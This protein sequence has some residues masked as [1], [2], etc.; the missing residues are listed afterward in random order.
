MRR[1]RA[2][3]LLGAMLGPTVG[4][5]AAASS[6][7]AEECGCGAGAL[8]PMHHD[9]AKQKQSHNTDGNSSKDVTCIGAANQQANPSTPQIDLK[10][11]GVAV[12][13]NVFVPPVSDGVTFSR[14]EQAI[15]RTISPPYI[16]P[17]Q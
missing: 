13:L 16:P 2:L 14:V 12:V 17:R 3:I 7:Q 11:T 6:S 8:C 10:T 9:P 4:L 15:A 5:A 1:L